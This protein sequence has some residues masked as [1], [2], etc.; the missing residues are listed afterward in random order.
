[1]Y[2]PLVIRSRRRFLAGGLGAAALLAL[3]GALESRAYRYAD[4]GG[5]RALSPKQYAV[6]VAV[7]ARYLGGMAAP[8]A[9]EVARFVD[10]YLAG[11]ADYVR[12]D[13]CRLLGLL[14]H[15]PQLFLGHAR[16]FSALGPAEQDAH[17]ASW[18]QSRLAQ[19]RAGHGA[20]REL[21]S[22]GIYRDSRTWGALGYRGPVVPRG[23]RGS[24]RD[25]IEPG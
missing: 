14:E 21:C 10:G 19:R 20:L 3:G 25:P 18:A 12:T 17:L 9:A 22:L 5:L 11:S 16:R 15:A 6:L 23:Y 24:E 8:T 7:A 4:P 1:V 13:V 2:H